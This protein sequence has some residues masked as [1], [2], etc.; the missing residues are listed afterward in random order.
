MPI[1]LGQELEDFKANF[2]KEVEQQAD[3]LLKKYRLPKDEPS[4]SDL[5]ASILL[6][7]RKLK[8]DRLRELE[9]GK[10]EKAELEK[11][12]QEKFLDAA[13]KIYGKTP[14]PIEHDHYMS[15]ETDRLLKSLYNFEGNL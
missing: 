3:E 15:V 5:Q 11:T 14:E 8:A 2:M 12:S 9:A 7:L 6:E 13:S 10:L 4:P 1:L